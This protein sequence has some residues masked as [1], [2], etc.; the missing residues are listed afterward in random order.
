VQAEALQ[1]LKSARA[2]TIRLNARQLAEANELLTPFVLTMEGQVAAQPPASTGEHGEFDAAL[3]R[4]TPLFSEAAMAAQLT[5]RERIVLDRLQSTASLEYIA[6]SLVVSINTVKTQ[7][8]SI[9]RKLGA[10]SREEAVRIAYDLGLLRP[11]LPIGRNRYEGDDRI[12]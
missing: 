12:A 4:I 10:N 7:T 5:Q 6:R 2:S 3:A 9:Y 1:R 8:R 11:R